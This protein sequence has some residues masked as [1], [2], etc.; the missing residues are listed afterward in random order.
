MGHSGSCFYP[1]GP[2]LISP[3]PFKMCFVLAYACPHTGNLHI[4]KK[5]FLHIV[6]LLLTVGLVQESALAADARK[7]FYADFSVE[8]VAQPSTQ[9]PSGDR[10][11]PTRHPTATM[12]REIAQK[13]LADQHS[14]HPIA[15]DFEPIV[16]SKNLPISKPVKLMPLQNGW[17]ALTGIWDGFIHIVDFGKSKRVGD[18]KIARG[19]SDAVMSKDGTTVASVAGNHI[20]IKTAANAWSESKIRALLEGT[21]TK[22]FISDDGETIAAMRNGKPTDHPNEPTV[23]LV[24]HRNI[25]ALIYGERK[26]KIILS[27][28]GRRLFSYEYDGKVSMWEIPKYPSKA[29]LKCTTPTKVIFPGT[30][31]YPGPGLRDMA[32][33]FTGDLLVTLSEDAA[34]RIYRSDTASPKTIPIQVP[35]EAGPLVLC[36]S[37]NDRQIA[38]GH[39]DGTVRLWDVERGALI[40]LFGHTDKESGKPVHSIALTKD[41]LV[42]ASSDSGFWGWR[43]ARPLLSFRPRIW[44]RRKRQ[45]TALG[46]RLEILR[47]KAGIGRTMLAGRLGV[48]GDTIH[49]IETGE[50][51]DFKDP[52][53]WRA[54][55]DLLKTDV[56]VLLTEHPR[57]EA[58]AKLPF[59]EDRVLLLCQTEGIL[60]SVL[61]QEWDLKIRQI[62]ETSEPAVVNWANERD[63]IRRGL[64]PHPLFSS[65]LSERLHSNPEELFGKGLL[66]TTFLAT[67]N[68]VAEDGKFM[69]KQ[70][71]D[72]EEIFETILRD[73][74]PGGLR[75]KLDQG[76][77]TVQD[78]ARSLANRNISIGTL[79]RGFRKLTD[80]LHWLNAHPNP[81]IAHGKAYGLT[82]E[83]ALRAAA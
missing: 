78:Y 44:Y 19:D 2:W 53:R 45:P 8:A 68:L 10:D 4:M 27:G 24:R 18:I 15:S 35:S 30:L 75:A 32:T 60:F 64:A 63:R 54:L 7:G 79:H 38:T 81:H 29:P 26:T 56:F 39:Y 20:F 46:Q 51:T 3:K 49:S 42:V 34:I 33:D 47:K 66:A 71:S 83:G 62:R 23:V 61:R 22:V 73:P 5:F 40:A 52:S 28:D 58:M 59:W 13:A 36:L 50:T 9:F 67:G 48:S 69:A 77:L 80:E 11:S 21:L 57:V 25:C 70:G 76:V 16:M 74:V 37:S 17:T 41:E 6:A 55:A 1:A 43:T 31:E 12:A 82:T 14:K 65:W 72:P